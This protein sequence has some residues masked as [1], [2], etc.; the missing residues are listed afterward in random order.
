MSMRPV[1]LDHALPQQ[2]G[3]WLP[4]ALLAVGILAALGLAGAIRQVSVQASA[5]ENDALRLQH[6]QPAGSARAGTEPAAQQEEIVAVQAA[7]AELALPWESLFKALEQTRNPRVRLVEMTPDPKQHKLRISAEAAASGDMLD[8]V[9]VLGRQ[10]MLKDVLLLA[11]TR[12][13]EKV[14]F[15]V[16]AVWEAQAMAVDAHS[17]LPQAEEGNVEGAAMPEERAR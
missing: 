2:T 7:M 4:R 6:P 5:L 3:R 14:R 15:D 9:K 1:T 17:P 12:E 8:Y 10:P 16:E 11:H 13:E